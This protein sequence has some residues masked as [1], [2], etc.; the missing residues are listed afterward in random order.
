MELGGNGGATALSL[1]AEQLRSTG[2]SAERSLLSLLII[3]VVLLLAHS[4]RGHFESPLAGSG[5]LSVAPGRSGGAHT[6][7][8]AQNYSSISSTGWQSPEQP[9]RLNSPLQG[10]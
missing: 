2:L 8:A 1:V 4:G 5:I 10:G 7:F 6:V 9:E 3:T